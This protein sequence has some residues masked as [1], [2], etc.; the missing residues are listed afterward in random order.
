MIDNLKVWLL[1]VGLKKLGPSAIRG[2]VLG[3]ASWFIAKEG[4][5]SSYGIVS[6][7]VAKTTTIH[8]AQVSDALIVGLPALI[9]IILKLTSHTTVAVAKGQPISGDPALQVRRADDK[10]EEPK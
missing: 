2:A 1:E 5:L 7:A 6:D 10:T 8:W 9:A 3:L 4:L